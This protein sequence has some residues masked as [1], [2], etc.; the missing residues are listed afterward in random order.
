MP[1]GSVI[2]RRC[3]PWGGPSSDIRVRDGLITDVALHD[4]AIGEA[5]AGTNRPL[6]GPANDA[7]IIDGR[8]RIA[9]PTFSDVHVHLDSTRIGLP[10]RPHTGAPGVW[11]M[12]LNDRAHW[13]DAEVGITQRVSDTLGRMIA[14]G[15]TR[16]RSFCPSRCRLSARTV[17]SGPGCPRDTPRPMRD[18]GH[19][20]PSSWPA[21]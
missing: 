3:R 11:G 2:V 15:A 19:R 13:R 14:H 4:G 18:A 1:S 8:D 20:L 16:V 12:M 17:R 9:L 10:F 5:S 6:A 7:H 21:P